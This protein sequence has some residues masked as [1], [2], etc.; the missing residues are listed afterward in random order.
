MAT[1][2][3]TSAGLGS[4]IDVESL[5]TKL[6]A[7]ERRPITTLQS[8]EASYKSQLSAYGVL[9]GSLSSLQ[10]AAQALDTKSKFAAF[11]ANVADT[12]IATVAASTGASAASYDLTVTQ[13]ASAE[14]I[15]SAGY[16][17]STSAIASGTLTIKMGQ[18]STDGSTFTEYTDASGNP[19]KTV[20]IDISALKGN[21]TLAGLRDAINAS[22]AGVTASLVNDG[23]TS[24]YKLVLSSKETG[25]ANSFELSG[26]T[27]FNYSPT[28]YTPASPTDP[29]ETTPTGANNLMSLQRPADAK[30]S[31]DGIDITSSSNVVSTA[32][33]GVTL[34]LNKTNVGGTTKL[35][36]ES[37][38]QAMQD[39][40]NAFIK[41]YNDTVGLIKSQTKANPSTKVLGATDSTARTDGPLAGDTTA[42][43]IQSQLR[44]I[45]GGQV[46]SG[47]VSRLSDVGISIA[48]DGTLSLDSSKFQAALRNPDKDVAG[49]FAGDGTLNGIADQISTRISD[50]LNSTSGV[51]TARTEG[52]Q[53]T[54]TNMDKRIESLNL[55][56]DTIE[57][58]YRKQFNA[59]DSTIASMNSTS[60]YL[61][62][63]LN[64]L[65]SSYA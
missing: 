58:R 48:V 30:F 39:K 22:G 62:Q 38:T 1:G 45:V 28:N 49:L 27:G 16:A 44:S 37:D 47:S 35:N 15:R 52:I 54:I 65:M 9:K 26:L 46:G 5:V 61:T 2:S 8:R 32:V 43:T 59:M 34:T 63:Q 41:A 17:Q 12:T 36:V 19:S 57:A 18:L 23:G 7:L 25:T 14:K 64:S 60:S 29:R 33:Q 10:T 31:L 3:L 13:L 50:Y 42:R 51:I 20:S 55:R 4:G 40:V 6:M 53:K 21:N 11:K 56:M 24:P